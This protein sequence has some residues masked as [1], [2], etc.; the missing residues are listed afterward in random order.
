MSDISIESDDPDAYLLGDP[1]VRSKTPSKSIMLIQDK[2]ELL[3]TQ[4]LC[5]G[6]KTKD[7]TIIIHK[8]RA[9]R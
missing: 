6:I 7:Q 9:K 3:A 1:M 4:M 8:E 5:V 2:N